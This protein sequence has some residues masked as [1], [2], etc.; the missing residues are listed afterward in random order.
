MGRR[1]TPRIFVLLAAGCWLLATLPG[2][3]T[4][5]ERGQPLVPT[6]YQT[7]TGPYAVFTGV[8]VAADAPAIRHLQSLDRQLEAT[9]SMRIDPGDNPIEVYVLN[10]RKAFTHFLTFYYP[11]LP[12]RRAF[13]LAQGSRRVVYTFLGE[14]LEEDLRHEA[15]HALLHV[16]VGEIPLWLD[17]GLAEYFERPDD[18][19]GVNTEH[20]SRLPKDRE[21]GWIPD[22]ARLESLKDVRQMSPRDYREAWGW[23]HYLLNNSPESKAV[24]LGYLADLR[25]TPDTAPLSKRVLEAEG[26]SSRRMLA[27]L[28]RIREAPIAV[29]PPARDATVRLQNQTAESVPTS[30]PRR[31]FFGRIGAMFGLKGER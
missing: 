9:L 25:S 3:A 31:G 18:H 5:V 2:C 20:L 29:S 6:K 12:P 10:D 16:A 27:H 17:E 30:P 1:S 26:D 22:M 24:L 28:E 7:R 11:E 21:D 4:M 8:P 14:R 23:V 15:T 13:F 19:G